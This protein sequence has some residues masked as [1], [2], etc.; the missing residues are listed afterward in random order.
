MYTQNNI[1][2]ISTACPL[3]YNNM[4]RLGDGSH[5]G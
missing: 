4:G 2:K 1:H 5:R 3:V